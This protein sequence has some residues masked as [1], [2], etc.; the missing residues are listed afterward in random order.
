M[1][2]AR[3][4]AILTVV[5]SA[6]CQPP[7]PTGP[8]DE[9]VATWAGTESWELE[10]YGLHQQ[11]MSWVRVCIADVPAAC[12]EMCD[13]RTVQAPSRPESVP[14]RYTPQRH[15]LIRSPDAAATAGSDC[16]AYAPIW[17]SSWKG[18]WIGGLAPTW[19]IQTDARTG[20]ERMS[21]H[22]IPMRRRMLPTPPGE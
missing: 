3:F 9:D 11:R 12:Q 10:D 2:S 22:G 13:L 21:E 16:T 1:F 19:H 18:H 4:S 17:D 15:E 7:G 6:A 14:E 20:A 5:L 8:T